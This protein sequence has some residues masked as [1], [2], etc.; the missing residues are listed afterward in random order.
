MFSRVVSLGSFCGPAL[1]LERYGLRDASY[2]LDWV[3]CGI[4]PTL[5]LL[6]TNFEGFLLLENLE[7]DPLNPRIVH[8]LGSG[9]D[10]YHDFDPARSI[11][12]QY[13]VVQARYRR[14]I[15]RFL[16]GSG[17]RTLFV[18]YMADE[19][20]CQYLEANMGRFLEILRRSCADN[21]LLLIGN[22]GVPPTCGGLSVYL[23]HVD[24]GDLVARKFARANNQLSHLLKRLSYP[25]VKRVRNILR[26]LWNRPIR[27]RLDALRLRTRG[28]SESG[29]SGSRG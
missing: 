1:E 22:S 23:V 9:V 15:V 13:E 16:A 28:P 7:R 27:A 6:D 14:R 26:Y 21:E 18:R 19:A 4:Q 10:L 8:D 24:E 25:L 11:A 3:I 2:P 17:Q 20:E 5:C 29:G 12:E